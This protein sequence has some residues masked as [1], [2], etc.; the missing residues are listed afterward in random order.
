VSVRGGA[1]ALFGSKFIGLVC[2]GFND[3][4]IVMVTVWIRMCLFFGRVLKNY[5]FNYFIFGWYWKSY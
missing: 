4:A 5:F 3:R 1:V 2:F